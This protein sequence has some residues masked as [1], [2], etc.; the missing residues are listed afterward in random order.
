MVL[1]ET[2]ASDMAMSADSISSFSITKKMKNPYTYTLSEVL[3]ILPDW[4]EEVESIVD[5]IAGYHENQREYGAKL[6]IQKRLQ[7]NQQNR[8]KKVE[9]PLPFDMGRE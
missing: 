8:K 7:E 4:R 5:Q 9:K 1:G 2:C 3:G 6:D